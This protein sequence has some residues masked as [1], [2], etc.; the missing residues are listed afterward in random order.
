MIKQCM[1]CNKDFMTHEGPIMDGKRKYCSNSCSAKDTLN[2]FKRGYKP[3]IEQ[4]EKLRQVHMGRPSGKKGKRYVDKWGYSALHKWVYKNL[5]KAMQC[6]FC[7]S[8]H[9]VE[10]A[11]KSHEYLEDLSDW[12]QLCKKCHAQ[13]DKKLK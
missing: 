12:V 10:W 2:G 9:W 5:G 8:T 6:E 4:R 7:R 1:R 3:S 11:N 13:Y